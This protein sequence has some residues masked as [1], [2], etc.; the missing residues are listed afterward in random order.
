M[1]G[2]R[3]R[4]FRFIALD[5]YV[6]ALQA[7][8]FWGASPKHCVLRFGN[9]PDYLRDGIAR[10]LFTFPENSRARH[11]SRHLFHAAHYFCRC[12]SNRLG[13]GF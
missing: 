8:E 11:L 9:G 1:Q 3:I 10:C 4:N 7:P 2:G 5:N 6:E 13:V 12:I